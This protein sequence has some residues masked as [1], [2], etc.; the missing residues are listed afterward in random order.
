MYYCTGRTKKQI[1]GRDI[2]KLRNKET[3]KE[4]KG[5]ARERK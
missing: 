3:K 2:E 4:M 5:T 1:R